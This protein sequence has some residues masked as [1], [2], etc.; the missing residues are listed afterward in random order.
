MLPIP[1]KPSDQTPRR[2]PCAASSASQLPEHIEVERN[3]QEEDPEPPIFRKPDRNNVVRTSRLGISS[4]RRRWN[5]RTSRRMGGMVIERDVGEGGAVAGGDRR[6]SRRQPCVEGCRGVLGEGPIL[7]TRGG[8][9]GDQV[10]LVANAIN[11]VEIPD[12]GLKCLAGHPGLGDQELGGVVLTSGGLVELDGIRVETAISRILGD[13]AL[14]RAERS[15]QHVD[16]I[17]R[18]L[19]SAARGG[20]GDRGGRFG[21]GGGPLDT[22]GDLEGGHRGGPA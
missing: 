8:G 22:G 20:L 11:I 13:T 10:Q 6:G 15:P 9:G 3:R 2:K 14:E 21:A 17:R 4:S 19:A 18:M 12:H 1:T 16:T 7:R 5:I